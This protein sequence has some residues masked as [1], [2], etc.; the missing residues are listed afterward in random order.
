MSN[1][2][3]DCSIPVLTAS[4]EASQR[5]AFPAHFLSPHRVHSHTHIIHTLL[6]KSLTTVTLLLIEGRRD[7]L[8]LTPRAEVTAEPGQS[9]AFL[10][11]TLIAQKASQSAPQLTEIV[12][13]LE[14]S[15]AIVPCG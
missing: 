6:G 12:L 9:L 11:Y 4:T 8:S 13:D 3:P 15:R 1:S 10:F 2:Q 7:R 5:E 14:V